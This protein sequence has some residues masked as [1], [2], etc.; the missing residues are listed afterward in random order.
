V[1]FSV[2]NKPEK[3][4]EEEEVA[5]HDVTFLNALEA[6]IKYLCQSDTENSNVQQS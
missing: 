2:T 6:A 4:F 5:E 1:D 3:E